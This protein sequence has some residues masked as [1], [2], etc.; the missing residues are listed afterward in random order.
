MALSDNSLL[1]KTKTR[2]KFIDL[3]RSVAILLMLEGHFVDL[4]LDPAFRDPNNV[5]YAT[6]LYIRGFTA[7][8]FLT[9]TGIV[10]VYL[11]LNSRTEP[12]FKNVRIKKGFKRVFELIF[13]G[14]ALQLY[15]FHVLQCIAFGILTILLIFGIYKAVKVIPLWVY[16]ALT[17]TVLFVSNLT[18]AHLPINLP[19]PENAPF[20]I[21]NMI[22]GPGHRAVF[23]IIPWMGFTMY[24]AMIGCL[25]HDLKNHVAKWRFAFSFLTIGFVFFWFTKPTMIG[26][27][28]MVFGKI[29]L[30]YKLDWLY[31]RFGMVLMILG[32]LMIIE[33]LMGEIR[34]NLFLKIGQ[35]TLTIYIIHMIL[36]Y[37]SLTGIGVNDYFN[38][39][40]TPWE[41]AIGALTFISVHL[42]I[43]YFLDYIKEKLE[44]ILKP[45]RKFWELV[46]GIKPAKD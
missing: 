1:K 22:H 43:I 28:R 13:W 24:G 40:L 37:G 44:F 38:K 46:Y 2:L 27:D 11:M 34:Q 15:A 42:L 31:E 14:Y 36:L 25:L 30:F 4:T 7:P 41:A 29:D 5:I 32:T 10:F 8:M 26:L 35:N 16:Y 39:N 3:A 18:M 33:K 9:V 19:W 21:Q 20:F 45:I 12:F 23:P 6:W 17:G